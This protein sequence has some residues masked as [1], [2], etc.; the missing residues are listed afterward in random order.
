MSTAYNAAARGQPAPTGRSSERETLRAIV[1]LAQIALGSGDAAPPAASAA[2]P[3][4]L[5]T[6]AKARYAAR[7][8]RDRAFGAHP[9]LFAD[10][11]WDIMLDLCAAQHDGR[12]V[13]VSSACIAASVAPTTALRWIA[14][15][16][17]RGLVERT[18]DDRDGRRHFLKLS[19]EGLR[20]VEQ[21]LAGY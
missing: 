14:T 8:H 9:N 12:A 18:A 20:L 15:L 16:E 19:I 2:A 11:A 10:P 13:S 5:A 21:A 4:S 17:G 3:R 6:Q 1:R 7:R